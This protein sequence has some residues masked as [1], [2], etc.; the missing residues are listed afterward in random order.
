MTVYF[1]L[2][3]VVVVVLWLTSGVRRIGAISV[4]TPIGTRPETALLLVDLQTVFWLHG[5]YTDAAKSDA[6]AVILNEIK[7]AKAEGYPIIA[8]RQEWS[9]SSTKAIAR[10]MMKGQ[11]IAGTSGTELA[12]LFA[13]GPDHVL[14]KRVQDAFETGALD[15]LFD[16]LR[17]G[18]LRIVGLDFNYCVLKTALAA[19]KRGYEVTVVERGTLAASSTEAAQEVLAAQGV[20]LA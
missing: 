16:K 3:A 2:I 9:I 7:A 19:R 17:V 10:L 20:V 6:E 18:R 11:A 13:H 1:L 5:P 12:A 14:V 8:V 4:G 15:A